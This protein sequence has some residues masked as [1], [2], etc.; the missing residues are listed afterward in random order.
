MSERGYGNSVKV[1]DRFGVEYREHTTPK[2]SHN[3]DTAFA[4][5]VWEVMDEIGRNE[6]VAN[7][8]EK[9]KIRKQVIY[10]LAKA[11]YKDLILEKDNGGL[12]EARWFRLNELQDIKTYGDILPFITKAVALI[13]E[14]E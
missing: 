10:F 2:P 8:P 3:T 11:D 12:D 5:S 13:S 9:G 1:V 6:Y 14:K 7:H 4:S